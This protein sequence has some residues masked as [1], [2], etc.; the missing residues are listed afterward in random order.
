MS[1]S[2]V[3]RN[4]KEF[5][6]K[7]RTT[8]PRPAF[9]LKHPLVAPPVTANYSLIGQAFDYL[10]RFY[11][12]YRYKKHVEGNADWIADSAVEIILNKVRQTKEKHIFIGFNRNI[13]VSRLQLA[14]T[15][16]TLHRIAKENHKRFLKT[17]EIN[18]DLLAS[19]L[20]LAR[21]DITVRRGIIDE[22]VGTELKGDIQ[23]LRNL[24]GA[25][26]D[27][28][29]QIND[30]L[31]LNPTFGDGS[32]LVY[33]ADGDLILDNCIVDIKTTKHLVLERRDLNQIIGYYL[34]YLVG[35]ITDVKNKSDITHLGI[36]FSR[37]GV[38]WKF[39]VAEL[40]TADKLQEFKEWFI[41]HVDQ[42]FTGGKIS[43]REMIKEREQRKE[44]PVKTKMPVVK[45]K[46][47][48]R[49]TKTTSKKKKLKGKK[50]SK[51]KKV[52]S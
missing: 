31:V 24:F 3:I 13:P 7:I 38:L 33:G 19:C 10:L 27:G 26:N 44:L 43:F 25:I 41:D 11:L 50:A 23:D 1:L 48:K 9:G 46:L 18:D 35:G 4:S 12:Q 2:D 32:S 36:Y 42:F 28:T 45:T 20:F 39:P 21:L 52:K 30:R 49:G 16:S 47:K 15:V 22:R 5:G 51:S 34:L 40:G 6:E 14:L 29:F 17:G 8:L 37:Y